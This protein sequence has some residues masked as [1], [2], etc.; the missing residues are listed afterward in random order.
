MRT[1]HFANQKQVLDFVDGGIQY[2]FIWF[3]V[4]HVH[5]ATIIMIQILVYHDYSICST[6][7]ENTGYRD[8][9]V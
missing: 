3:I 1:M 9:C 8:E 6:D 7:V 5:A 4:I 2:C